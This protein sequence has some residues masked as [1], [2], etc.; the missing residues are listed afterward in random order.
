VATLEANFD[1]ERVARVVGA[2][3][4]YVRTRYAGPQ[5]TRKEVGEVLMGAQYIA[6]EVT[7]CF[8]DRDIRQDH[9]SQRTRVYPA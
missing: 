5:P 9:P 8:S 7:R 6:S 3:P 4:D 2:F 1:G